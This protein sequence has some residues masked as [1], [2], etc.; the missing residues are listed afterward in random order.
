MKVAEQLEFYSNAIAGFMVAQSVAF[1][2]AF[3]T[4]AIFSCEFTE[5][6]SLAIFLLVHFALSSAVASW[7]LWALAK[8]MVALCSEGPDAPRAAG[9]FGSGRSWQ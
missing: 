3:G 8:R 2:Y 1:S 6:T 9:T 7:A 5:H 4:Q